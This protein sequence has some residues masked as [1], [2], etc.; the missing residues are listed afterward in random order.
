MDVTEHSVEV[1]IV[2]NWRAIFP[3]LTLIERQYAI[4]DGVMD[5]LAKDDDG[6]V[7]IELK[8]GPDTRD[9]DTAVGQVMRYMSYVQSKNTHVDRGVRAIIYVDSIPL[10]YS[11]LEYDGIEIEEFAPNLVTIMRNE[12]LPY[13]TGRQWNSIEDLEK[14]AAEERE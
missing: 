6:W 11:G 12:E 13:E 2:E 5:I 1:M 8:V 14:L 9:M 10:P 7:V 3:T 4:P